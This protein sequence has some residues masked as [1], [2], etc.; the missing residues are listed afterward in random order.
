MKRVL[1][2][3]AA[4]AAHRWRLEGTPTRVLARR[5][6]VCDSTLLTHWRHLGLALGTPK[7]ALTITEVR[8][9]AIKIDAG[10]AS[11]GEVAAELGRHP[12]Q[13]SV[14]VRR[15]LG[16][17]TLPMPSR[18]V[19]RNRRVFELL[20]AGATWWDVFEDLDVSF[21]GT[22]PGRLRGSLLHGVLSYCRRAGIPV[23]PAARA[24]LNAARR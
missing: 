8:T 11:L 19:L 2:E 1:T 9:A 4:R 3:D 13:L 18:K 21:E 12:Q 5:L 15:S 6:K 16:R 23:P 20:R 17:R 14:L 7:R 22:T 10:Q 24:H